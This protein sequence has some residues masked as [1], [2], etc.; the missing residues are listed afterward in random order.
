MTPAIARCE[1][2]TKKGIKPLAIVK[3][4]QMYKYCSSHS[5]IKHTIIHVMEHAHI[6]LL[7]EQQQVLLI[8]DLLPT[9]FHWSPKDL[10]TLLVQFL[11]R[12]RKRCKISAI[13]YK[14]LGSTFFYPFIT[15]SGTRAEELHYTKSHL[16]FCVY[17][18]KTLSD[19]SSLRIF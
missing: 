1:C 12:D 2:L 13:K 17:L 4:K 15:F 6:Q 11:L 16:F 19:T 9:H 5:T 10:N 14:T 8:S 7:E 3:H 18:K